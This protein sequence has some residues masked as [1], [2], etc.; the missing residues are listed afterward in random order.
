[1]LFKH[2]QSFWIVEFQV[3]NA[4]DVDQQQEQFLLVA[5]AITVTPSMLRLAYP[6]SSLKT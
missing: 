5:I 3:R 1:M 6:V 2:V 4:L